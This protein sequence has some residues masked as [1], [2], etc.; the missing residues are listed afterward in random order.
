[1]IELYLHLKICLDYFPGGLKYAELWNSTHLEFWVPVPKVVEVIL[2]YLYALVLHRFISRFVRGLW[3]NRTHLPLFQNMSVKIYTNF[4]LTSGGYN[5]K[6]NYLKDK[7]RHGMWVH[8]L[9]NN[10]A[11]SPLQHEYY[12]W[13]R[14]SICYEKAVKFYPEIIVFLLWN[15]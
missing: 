13:H 2:W 10:L 14:R 9:L 12:F 11:T 8:I 6:I 7:M 5:L 3:F 1:M 15:N 4:I